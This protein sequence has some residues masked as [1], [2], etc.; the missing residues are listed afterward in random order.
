MD[1]SSAPPI[2]R[3]ENLGTIDTS[4]SDCLGEIP[5]F[6]LPAENEALTVIEIVFPAGTSKENKPLQATAC[7]AMLTEGTDKFTSERISE[8]QDYYGAK[9]QA[10]I[11]KDH[12]SVSLT[13]LS[14]HLDLLIP[15]LGSIAINP[16]FPEKE[17]IRY[18][19]RARAALE[20]NLKKVE[21][22]CRLLFS[23]SFFGSSKYSERFRPEDYDNLE[24]VDLE[25]FFLEN[26]KISQAQ[27]FVA[28]GAIDR[29]L[30][31]LK[32]VIKSPVAKI[33]KYSK[34]VLN[35]LR[36]LATIE[37][38]EA[39]QSGIRMGIESL[40]PTHPDYVPL[41]M[42]S[43][44]LGGYF[45]SRLMQ[46]IREDKGFTYGIGSTI[47]NLAS[48]SYISISTQVGFEHTE[49][50]LYEIKKEIELLRNAIVSK[51]ELDLVKNY[52]AG[53]LLKNMDGPYRKISLL[54]QM[55]Q[56]ELNDDYH[57]L[58][59]KSVYETTSEDILRAAQSYLNPDNFTTAIVG[60]GF[61]NIDSDY[62]SK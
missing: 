37:R 29:T 52:V 43:T 47:N 40:S 3:A 42:A 54:K 61:G 28:G 27:V 22:E 49:A 18:K 59:L 4:V 6:A 19:Q 44:I 7:S 39:L 50:T 11:G 15:L 38:E 30:S 62:S 34:I 8:I 55:I 5:V 13:C 21:I 17:F 2:N 36:G 56:F 23:R 48:L 58:F 1:R 35:P 46:N 57:Q 10:D 31:E 9:I 45:S 16:S 26:F 14:E 33:E 60:R 51:D 25:T 12:S 24:R 53:I 41:Y 20:V 32:K